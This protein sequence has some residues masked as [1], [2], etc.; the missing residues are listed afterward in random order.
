MENWE[1]FI[2]KLLELSGFVDWGVE[3]D[4]EHKRG[5]VFIRDHQELI[6]ENLPALV[7]NFNHLIQLVAKKNGIT[8]VFFDI[9]NYRRERENL[10]S[11]LARAAARKVV[12]TNQEIALPA[13]NAY[14]RR[15]VHVEL[16]A[17]PEV[18]T[19]S[20]GAGKDRHVTIRLIKEN[21]LQGSGVLKENRAPE[22][23]TNQEGNGERI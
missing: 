3:I 22:L 16:A 7:K 14:E 17:H 9:N 18:A 23:N 10:I 13:M 5:S 2:K 11:E 6:K 15:L 20:S 8:P 19:E 12:A 4:E 1:T 21:E